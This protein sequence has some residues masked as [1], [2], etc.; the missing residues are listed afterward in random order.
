MSPD[1]QRP[2]GL[3]APVAKAPEEHMK[4]RILAVDDNP[5]NLDALVALLGDSYDLRVAIDGRS[6]LRLLDRGFI[7]DLM[8]LDIM[9]PEMNGY[10]LCEQLKERPA[11]KDIPFIFLSA[12]DNEEDETQGLILGAADYISKP[13]QPAILLQRIRLHLEL[14]NY[15]DKLE[16]LVAEKTRKLREAEQKALQQEAI[17]RELFNNMGNGVAV[18]G[19]IGDGTD[20]IIENLNRSGAMMFKTPLTDVLNKPVTV[21]GK[22]AADGDLVPLIR[23]VW[24]SGQ[25][26]QLAARRLQIDDHLQWIEGYLYK[27]PTGQVVGIYDDVTE[28]KEI[29]RKIIRA[30]EEWEKTFDAMADCVTILDRD[31]RIIRANKAT[32]D[33]FG[34]P[35]SSLIGQHCFELFA[36]ENA[37][38]TDCPALATLADVAQGSQPLTHQYRGRTFDVSC[39]LLTDDASSTP[40][41]IHVARDVTEHRQ[42]Q[43]EVNRAHRLASIG[44]LAA[45]VAHEINNPNGLILHNSQ[46][47]KDVF[48]DLQPVLEDCLERNAD[49]SPGGLEAE[50]IIDTLPQMIDDINGASRRIKFIVTEL[51]DFSSYD[52]ND[53]LCDIDLNQ[54]VCSSAYLV[55]NTLKNATRNF[56]VALADELPLVRGVATRLEQ[57]IINLLINAS[58]ALEN[59]DEEIRLETDFDPSRQVVRVLVKDTGTGIPEHLRDHICEPF[60]TTK[61]Q[62]GG[63]GLGLSVST[64]IV[65]AHNGNLIFVPNQ[66]KGTIFILELPAG[67]N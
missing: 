44:E 4:A 59:P 38:C 46:L 13:F 2:G 64:R 23:R 32:H 53:E 27:I 21:L 36:A 45:G 52:N 25:P 3:S 10:Q 34:A 9:M 19:A 16:Q 65:K 5:I 51:R 18:Y 60:V 14:K 39:S 20:F 55:K 57:V 28:K 17:Y 31:L 33:L 40:Y 6:A 54:V 24:E 7:P 22:G 47:V 62:K 1:Q 42:L 37:A 35:Y 41:L 43:E 15:R 8:L 61:R 66:P 29:E 49:I 67:E 56:Q 12:L 48:Q 26:E 30:K 11:L 63:A 58:Q 50:D